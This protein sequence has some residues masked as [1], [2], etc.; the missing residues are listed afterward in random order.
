M[1]SNENL[2]SNGSTTILQHQ[3]QQYGDLIAT[4]NVL[5]DEAAA[6]IERRTTIQQKQWTCQMNHFAPCENHNASCFFSFG[7]EPVR[8]LTD[9]KPL[10]D[11]QGSI[12]SIERYL[13]TK[14]L[15]NDL[16][17]RPGPGNQ[18]LT[19]M[20]GEAVSRTLNEAFGFDGWCLEVKSTNREECKQDEKGR[21]SVSY[22]ATVRL[23]IRKSGAY[24][25]DVGAG[26]SKDKDMGQ[27]IANAL[28]SSVT[29]AMKRAARHFGEK[30]G[31]CEYVIVCKRGWSNFL[32]LICYVLLILKSFCIAALYSGNFNIMKAPVTLEEALIRLQTDAESS[33][34]KR[35][36]LPPPCKD[37]KRLECSN[38]GAID[39]PPESKVIGGTNTRPA[40]ITNDQSVVH[41]V[42]KVIVPMGKGN[43]TK[44]HYSTLMSTNIAKPYQ[45]NKSTTVEV[46]A[47]QVEFISTANTSTAGGTDNLGIKE[48]TFDSI[49]SHSNSSPPETRNSNTNDGLQKS[50]IANS[51][52][53]QQQGASNTLR[54]STVMEK[55]HGQ[56]LNLSSTSVI[57]TYRQ[58]KQDIQIQNNFHGL[59]DGIRPQSTFGS[60]NGEPWKSD[61]PLPAETSVFLPRSTGSHPSI[62]A[63]VTNHLHCIDKRVIGDAKRPFPDTKAQLEQPKRMALPNP[64]AARNRTSL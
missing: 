49:P 13:A 25:E 43:E 19:Y 30:L 57:A 26:C 52:G 22:T 21:W 10:V 32:A 50:A 5:G 58:Q 1:S 33:R 8:N 41:H 15:R 48:K 64:Y 4:A 36:A 53:G 31:N 46:A 40:L 24:K 38:N 61:P 34:R 11:P 60:N 55:S 7:T 16:S 28:K 6:A 42:T 63:D 44:H 59:T 18:K 35:K 3:V 12:I 20:S 29:D 39:A 62:M 2:Y 37:E 45:P 9:G 17:S 27:A 47:N 23:I 14:P 51:C 56:N 54:S